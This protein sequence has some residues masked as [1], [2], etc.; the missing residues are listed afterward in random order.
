MNRIRPSRLRF[1]VGFLLEAE[2]GT[3]RTIELD[4]PSVQVE[5]VTLTPLT[6]ALTMSRTT[7][8]IYVRGVLSTVM[9]AECVRCLEEALVSLSVEVNE[10]FY[11]PPHAAPIGEHVVGENGFI[12]LGP[13]VRELALLELP[14]QTL[15]KPDCQGLCMVCGFNLNEGDCGCVEDD[16]DPRLALLGQLLD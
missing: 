4:Y 9:G 8:G 7:E 3:S 2:F 14:M 11:Y 1:N 10:L 15:C 12:N 13:L 5:D 6:G 16:I